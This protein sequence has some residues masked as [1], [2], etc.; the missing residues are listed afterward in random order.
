[1]ENSKPLVY[2]V[3]DVEEM[4]SLISMYLEKSEIAT[5]AFATAEDALEELKNSA[6]PD[7]IILDL[8]LPGMSGFE[9]LKIFRETCDK[10]IPVI[11]VSAR[12]ADEDIITGL[13]FGADEFVTKP[14]SPRVLVAR[15]E[16]NLRRQALITAKA[17]DTLEFGEYTILLNSCVLKKG[18]VKIPLSTKE[19]E[20]LEFL[21]KHANETLSPEQIYDNVWKVSY[22]DVTAVAVY[23]QRLRKKLEKDPLK[24]VY[25]QTVYRRGYMFKK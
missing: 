3:E 24:P 10:A 23:I 9:F 16:A 1:M 17:E 5:K 21:V 22:G 2:I 13:S 7:L 20:V 12:D 25:I 8:N 6:L 18:T 14:F 19:Y 4:S 11:I 15:V